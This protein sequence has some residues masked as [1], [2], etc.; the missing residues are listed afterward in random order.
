M[1]DETPP[2]R[3]RQR[4]EYLATATRAI[5]RDI[6]EELEQADPLQSVALLRTLADFANGAR[7]LSLRLAGSPLRRSKRVPY[8]DDSTDGY[9]EGP[10]GPLLL[11]NPG[12]PLETFGA[13]SIEAFLAMARHALGNMGAPTLGDLLNVRERL[14][15]SPHPDP[16]LSSMIT[17]A[18][19]GRL[20]QVPGVPSDAG[21]P[22]APLPAEALDD[23]SNP[24]DE[25]AP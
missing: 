12:N 5:L 4:R 13:Q 21:L 14:Q 1:A 11:Q 7:Q 15:L 9:E 20:A 3:A 16:T 2:D 22:L 23:S 6:V 24:T 18:I 25:D 17:L 8:G 19:Q 10:E